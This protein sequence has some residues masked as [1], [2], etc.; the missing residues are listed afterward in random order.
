MRLQDSLGEAQHPLLVGD[1]KVGIGEAAEVSRVEPFDL[2]RVEYSAASLAQRHP[3][4]LA[5]VVVSPWSAAAWA[6]VLLIRPLSAGAV[7]RS[8]S[9]PASPIPDMD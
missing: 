6:L 2:D 1:P 8:F 3:G 4:R 7:A 5:P 9:M